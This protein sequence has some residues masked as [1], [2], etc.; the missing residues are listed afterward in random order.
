MAHA[1]ASTGTAIP[2]PGDPH[3]Q[4]DE[5]TSAY[6]DGVERHRHT[7]QTGDYPPVQSAGLDINDAVSWNDN[8][9]TGLSE[10]AFA[11][12]A[13]ATLD[14]QAIGTDAA[15]D[16][17]Y[18]PP[19]AG[20][21]QITA[22][23]A[24]NTAAGNGITGLAAPAGVTY[25]PGT[26]EYRFQQDTGTGLDGSV[27]GIR[28]RADGAGTTGYSE[29][30]AIGTGGALA[31]AEQGATFEARLR[32]PTGWQ[33]AAVA[34]AEAF[35]PPQALYAFA[36][37]ISGQIGPGPEAGL[38]ATGT[39]TPT[40]VAGSKT[41]VSQGGRWIRIGNL[42]FIQFEV[43]YTGGVGITNKV[44]AGAPIQETSS[45]RGTFGPTEI[46]SGLAWDVDSLPWTRYNCRFNTVSGEII[47]ADDT[48]VSGAAP[49]QAIFQ[50]SL[51]FFLD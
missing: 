43:G 6:L 34:H 44:I 7:G 45:V 46:P 17:Y 23:G 21:V 49:A 41:Y 33:A 40:I 36:T 5:Q 38:I 13:P 16:L 39:F 4:A 27:R 42:G 50:G 47:I 12:R 11:V 18:K 51:W 31:L 9:L 1:G 20:A 29:I 10:A 15:G 26:G 14:D 19:G 28:I 48:G 37:G 25:T 32:S 35:V 3:Y 2:D 22:G 30:R 8:D 24:L